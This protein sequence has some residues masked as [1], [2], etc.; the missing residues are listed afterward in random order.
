MESIGDI[1]NENV[2]KLIGKVVIS[3]Q[4]YEDTP[5][6]G[7]HYMAAMAQCAQ[8]GGAS[9][10]RACWPQDI[11]AIKEVVD[12]PIIGIYKEFHEGVDRLD[13]IY[14]T[15]DFNRAKEIIE[16]GSDIIAIDCTIKENRGYDELCALLKQI[17]DAYPHIGIMADLATVEEAVLMDQ[18]GYVDIISTTLSGYTR[19][20]LSQKKDG[21]DLELI[22]QIKEKVSLP[23]NA[24]GRVWEKQDLIDCLDAGADIVSIGSSVTRPHLITERF[25]KINDEY[26]NK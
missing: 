17:K 4:A 23:V 20:S 9:G 2:K 10:I 21:P 7:S 24:E 5:L 6:Y 25:V 3:C 11:K 18:C 22:K 15:P 13:D 12:L 8:M 19:N 26:Q 16:A 14:I 1:M